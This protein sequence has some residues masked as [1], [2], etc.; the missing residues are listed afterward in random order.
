MARRNEIQEERERRDVETHPFKYYPIEPK[1]RFKS[2][3]FI[4]A[5]K[6]LEGDMNPWQEALIKD[7]FNPK[8]R[9][10]VSSKLYGDP[11]LHNG[12]QP[13]MVRKEIREACKDG[14]KKMAQYVDNN[15]NDFLKLFEGNSLLKLLV[16][17]PL[18]KTKNSEHNK[19]VSAVNHM[20]K[21][22]NIAK[23]EDIDKMREIVFESI[24]QRNIPDWAKKVAAY[25]AKDANYL[26]FLY[27][28]DVARADYNLKKIISPEGK[29]DES[30]A[31][32]VIRNSI[33]KAK[34]EYDAE[35]DE[36]KK[37]D[38]WD[39]D[40]E[41]A[42]TAIARNAYPLAVKDYIRRTGHDDEGKADEVRER[43]QER[44]DLGMA[45]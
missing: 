45:A 20:K 15:L 2:L 26:K 32:T 8:I 34:D 28:G 22:A 11:T 7:P 19:V 10:K 29:I 4:I 25:F 1:K 24:K 39:D 40:I 6:E 13:E 44:K 38:I 14:T 33:K 41:P 31:K 12:K 5:E 43:E 17:M 18:Y 36:G 35:K 42:Y 27:N 23:E 16:S 3:D 37:G 21:L 9:E 30:R